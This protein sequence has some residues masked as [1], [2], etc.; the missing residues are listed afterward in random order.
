MSF[1]KIKTI[2]LYILPIIL[3]TS[4]DQPLNIDDVRLNFSPENVII[5]NLSLGFIM[6]GVALQLRVSN[7]IQVF[8]FPKSVLAGF[9]SQFLALP[10]FT[11]LLILV[12]KPSPSI[13]LGMILVASCPGGN[14]SNFMTSFAKGNTA[15]SVCMTAIASILAVF[16][17]PLNL[18]IWGNLYQPTSEIINE[19]SIDFFEML[20]IIGVILILP[21]ILGMLLRN[22][23]PKVADGLNK[24][25]QI[26]SIVIFVGIVFFA[27]SANFNLF[28]NY[29][30]AVL[31]IVLAHN[32][33]GILTGLTIAK[34]FKLPKEDKKTLAIET[35]I[36]NSGL[37]LGLIFTFFDGL[38]GM[39]II[40]G[41]WGIWHIL[42]GLSIAY[43]FRKKW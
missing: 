4:C 18:S 31:F 2:C 1:I 7:F 24:F 11:F 37:G 14:I 34:L 9:L 13:A 27:F 43:F 33:V 15:L 22:Y 30:G 40:A 28:T 17:T 10:L 8:K 35:G 12:L 5:L 23:L 41:W 6:F 21:L 29:I 42:S 36:Q 32:S 39:A 19:I 16:M 25:M 20:E 38:G 3:L 26:S